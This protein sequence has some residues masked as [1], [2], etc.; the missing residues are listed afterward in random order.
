[1]MPKTKFQSFIFTILMVFLM[2]FCMTTYTLSIQLGTL[3]SQVFYMAIK[4][5][6]LEYIVVF[7]LIFFVM[8]DRSIK[9]ARKM[10]DFKTTPPIFMT[11]LIQCLTVCQIVPVITLFAT[12]IHHGIGTDCFFIWLQLMVECFPMALCLQLFFVGPFVRTV[13]RKIF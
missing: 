13:F 9:T 12:M 10:L 11:L 2:V 3:N 5:M 6:W 1:M 8:T 7:F 4:E